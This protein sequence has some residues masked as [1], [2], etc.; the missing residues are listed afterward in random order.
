MSIVVNYTKAQY[1]AEIAELEGYYNQLSTHLSRMEELKS[2]I[3]EF[4]DDENAQKSAN[5][6]VTQIRHVQSTMDRTSEMISFYKS[7]IEEMDG[8]NLKIGDLLESAI[9]ILGTVV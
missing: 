7:A 9:K 2:Q 3:F 4:W 8:V 5:V 1:Q 6:L